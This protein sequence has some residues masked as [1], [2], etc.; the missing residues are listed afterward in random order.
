[1]DAFTE[2]IV[3]PAAEAQTVDND[4]LVRTEPWG[5]RSVL[6]VEMSAESPDQLHYRLYVRDHDD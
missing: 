1:M 2:L 5:K 6:T 3:I 4:A